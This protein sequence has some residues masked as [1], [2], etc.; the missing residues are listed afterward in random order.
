M[1]MTQP[2]AQA[3]LARIMEDETF[4]RDLVAAMVGARQK[5][6]RDYGYEFSDEE[7]EKAMAGLAPGALGHAAKWFCEVPDDHRSSGGRHC[8]GGPWH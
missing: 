8:C 5:V 2:S 7:L 3:F 1:N 6:I 4:C